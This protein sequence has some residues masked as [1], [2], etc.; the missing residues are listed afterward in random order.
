MQGCGASAGGKLL[1]RN[2]A[3]RSSQCS[4]FRVHAGGDAELQACKITKCGDTGVL[5][6]DDGSTLLMMVRTSIKSCYF[7]GQYP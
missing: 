1:A 6:I 3:V 7:S 5:A 4:G 2:V